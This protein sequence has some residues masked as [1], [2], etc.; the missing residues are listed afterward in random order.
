MG[1]PISD[2]RPAWGFFYDPLIGKVR[3]LCG[4]QGKQKEKDDRKKSSRESK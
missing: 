1:K 3:P 4:G 2:T